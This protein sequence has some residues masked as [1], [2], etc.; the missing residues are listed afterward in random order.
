MN[1]R[2]LVNTYYKIYSSISILF[3]A[4]FWIT[5]YFKLKTINTII[6]IVWLIA[7]ALYITCVILIP[8]FKKKYF[9]V[10][11]AE[12]RSK[13][14]S[15]TKEQIEDYTEMSKFFNPIQSFAKDSLKELG[16]TCNPVF[17]NVWFSTCSESDY[18][19]SVDIELEMKIKSFYLEINDD[20]VV[21]LTKK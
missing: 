18:K 10:V 19:Y 21:T 1:Y 12:I 11:E 17:A 8:I 13:I 16:I 15:L 9:K 6:V 5:Y 2:N 20:G 4:A 14:S 3:L 7:L